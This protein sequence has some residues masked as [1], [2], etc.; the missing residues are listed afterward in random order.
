MTFTSRAL[1][2]KKKI[3][4]WHP[5]P[6][7]ATGNKPPNHWY[8]QCLWWCS[9]KCFHQHFHHWHALCWQH[10]FVTDLNSAGVA[11][12][13]LQHNACP[14]FSVRIPWH[15]VFDISTSS[16]TSWMVKWLLEWFT[17]WTFGMFSSF[18]N[19]KG[20]PE[21]SMSTEVQPSLKRLYHLW[22]CVRLMASSP[23]ACFNILKV[24]R[25]VYPNL[26]QNFTQTRCSWKSPSLNR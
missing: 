5:L 1:L 10:N 11:Q 16:A 14:N 19:V 9:L 23:K 18:S 20:C 22:V 24:S 26:K 12:I 7:K 4:F 21:H 8:E 25:T 2:A 6:L 17:S 13:W 15:V 3:L